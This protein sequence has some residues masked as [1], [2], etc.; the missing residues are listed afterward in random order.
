MHAAVYKVDPR[1]FPYIGDSS[2]ASIEKMWKGTKMEKKRLQSSGAG[3]PKR[4]K[5]DKKKEKR[6]RL[7]AAKAK[8]AAAEAAAVGALPPPRVAAGAAALVAGSAVGGGGGRCSAPPPRSP[9]APCAARASCVLFLCTAPDAPS[10]PASPSLPRPPVRPPS[11][12]ACPLP[13]PPPQIL[14]RALPPPQE[15]GSPEKEAEIAVSMYSPQGG[16]KAESTEE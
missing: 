8:A 13:L 4:S 7:K 2:W 15:K 16:E 5:M 1:W 9:S 10:H 14:T 3:K 6:A 12:R 11:F